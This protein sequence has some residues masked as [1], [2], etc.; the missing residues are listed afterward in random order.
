MK[1][2]KLKKNWTERRA[3]GRAPLPGSTNVNPVSS[4][5][6]LQIQN[7][8]KTIQK[9]DSFAIT[10]TNCVFLSKVKS[11]VLTCKPRDLDR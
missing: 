10:A 5:L 11:F 2:M 7:K 3:L 8:L 4:Q 1:G 6:P 9:H